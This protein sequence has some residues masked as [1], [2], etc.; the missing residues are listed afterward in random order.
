MKRYADLKRKDETF[1]VGEWVYLKLQ[2]YRQ[3]TMAQRQ[4]LKLSPC[5]YGPFQVT[6]RIEE[7]AFRLELPPTSSIHPVFHISQLKRKLG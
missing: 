7:V 3:M 2:P 1:E 6:Q 4:S 5:Y